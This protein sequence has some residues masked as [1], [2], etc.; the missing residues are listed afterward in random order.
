MIVWKYKFYVCNV[1][2]VLLNIV[3]SGKWGYDVL[4]LLGW[5]LD[6]NVSVL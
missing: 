6:I 1:G 4:W 5:N 3:E 2:K